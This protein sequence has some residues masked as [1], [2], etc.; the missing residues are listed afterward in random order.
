MCKSHEKDWM[1]NPGDP[2]QKT[3][4]YFSFKNSCCT[5][6]SNTMKCD[7]QAELEMKTFTQNLLNAV[8]WSRRSPTLTVKK[9]LL[10]YP[11]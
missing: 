7:I 10:A 11:W 1:E 6:L 8:V 2:K 5:S 9:R 4:H 3:K